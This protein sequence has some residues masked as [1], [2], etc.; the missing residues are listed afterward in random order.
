MRPTILILSCALGLLG[1]AANA[2]PPQFSY[3]YLGRK[4]A[5]P[6]VLWRSLADFDETIARLTRAQQTPARMERIA[7][8][9]KGIAA[10]PRYFLDRRPRAPRRKP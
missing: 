7:G 1:G 6:A 9:W 3:A 8:H 10:V 5:Y 4:K 2:A